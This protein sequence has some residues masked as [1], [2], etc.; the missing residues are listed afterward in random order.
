MP[1]D[2]RAS[3]HYKAH[4]D[5]TNDHLVIGKPA[6]DGVT[7]QWVL[8]LS[9]RIDNDD[10]SFNGVIVATIDPIYLTRIYNSVSIGKNGYIRVIG[11]DGGVRATI[12]TDIFC[13]RQG[14]FRRR[15]AQKSF[16][17]AGRIVLHEQPSQRPSSTAHSLQIGQGLSTFITV[18]LAADEIFSRLDAQQRTGCLAAAILSLLILIVTGFSVR[19]QLLRDA[20]K[21]RLE[22]VNM[23]LNATLANMPH[24]I[25]MFGADKRL[26]LA[27]DLYSIWPRSQGDNAGNDPSANPGSSHSPRMCPGRLAKI[28]NGPHGGGVPS[29]PR[30]HGQSTQRW[31]NPCG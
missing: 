20:A 2:Y 24:G 28:C 7:G 22:R 14:F 30:L 23:L 27:N 10:G 29:R 15:F 26:V 21:K 1:P 12:A 9:R 3:D 5:A 4:V 11:R 31:P 25:C 16:C 18:G 8:Q 13:Y 19:G 17:G 6:I